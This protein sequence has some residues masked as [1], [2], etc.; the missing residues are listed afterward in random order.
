MG[1]V[2]DVVIS[3]NP[4]NNV[5]GL[6]KFDFSDRYSVFDWGEMP[7]HIKGKGSSLCM[8]SAYFFEQMR[9]HGINTHYLGLGNGAMTYDLS[10]PVNVMDVRLARVLKPTA[11]E[12]DGNVKYD[13]GIFAA[14][15]GN[16][17]IP[18]EVIYR[19]V[20]PPKS[21]VFKRLKKGL[22]TLQDIGIDHDPQHGERLSPPMIDASTKYERFDRYP[23]WKE[24]SGL[25]A[26]TPAE[27]ALVR[28]WTQRGNTVITEGVQRSNLDNLDGKFEY[29]FDSDRK[30]MVVDTMGTLDECRFTYSG[31]DVSKQIPR[32]WYQFAQPDWV[33]QIEIAKDSGV[34]NWK[35]LVDIQ[36][37]PMPRRLVEVL[38]H[39]YGSVANAVLDSRLFDAPPLPDV[40]AEYEL[41]KQNE[42]GGKNE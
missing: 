25:A 14:Q 23:G 15:R 21:S 16:F 9:V 34:E 2:K 18:L 31:V 17:V 30:L 42:M 24:L 3:R 8:M 38:E 36:P 26:L 39:V 27:E 33:A 37:E 19:N 20:L 22:L 7:D 13:Y 28:Q 5:M 35:S 29:A 40:V 32:D 6:G 4:S 1:S 12:T 10:V 41:F 11:H